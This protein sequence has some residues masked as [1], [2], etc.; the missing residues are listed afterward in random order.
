MSDRSSLHP[1]C[2][3]PL[4]VS[5]HKTSRQIS[6]RLTPLPMIA[7]SMRSAMRR[8]GLRPRPHRRH[9]S[10]FHWTCFPRRRRKTCF[11][12]RSSCSRALN[13]GKIPWRSSMCPLRRRHR[14]KVRTRSS[15][16]T[17]LERL[18]P[19]RDLCLDRQRPAAILDS[20]PASLCP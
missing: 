14:S 19:P 1:V 12:H 5:T 3:T 11:R 18:R 6:F 4:P 20:A 15:R 13:R 17:C 2:L 9:L 7:I 16:A 10:A 8:Q